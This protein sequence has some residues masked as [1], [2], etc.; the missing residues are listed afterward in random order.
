MQNPTSYTSVARCHH[1]TSVARCTLTR[2]EILKPRT[3]D[4]LVPLSS[5]KKTNS[6]PPLNHLSVFAGYNTKAET[7]E[8]QMATEEPNINLIR[9][10]NKP[11]KLSTPNDATKMNVIIK[12][13]CS[14][15]RH[16]NPKDGRV[17]YPSQNGKLR[18]G[19]SSIHR[20]KHQTM[21]R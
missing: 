16:F 7:Q 4:G 21:K 6:A 9:P 10:F 3:Q 14:I 13:P 15:R 19:R 12:I 5:F 20:A 17:L 2:N 8:Q 18:L 1:F 11:N